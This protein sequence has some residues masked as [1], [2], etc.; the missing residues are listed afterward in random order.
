MLNTDSKGHLIE[1]FGEF[2]KEDAVSIPQ[3]MPAERIRSK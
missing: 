2:S 3:E 1:N